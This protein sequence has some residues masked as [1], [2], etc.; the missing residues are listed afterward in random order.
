MDQN[1]VKVRIAGSDFSILTDEEPGYAYELGKRIDNDL[2][3]IF[4][5]NPKLST[6]QA[7]ILLSLDYADAAH[8][9][10]D[11]VN[12]L[13]SQIK[14]Y[15]DDASNAKAKADFARREAERAKKEAEELRLQRDSLQAQ[16]D[17]IMK[18]LSSEG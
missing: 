2:S 3:E 13:R 10:A 17:E 15:L 16:L 5:S 9:S 12:A 1:K 18:R 14:D 8:K 7:A 4:R 11:A 6:T